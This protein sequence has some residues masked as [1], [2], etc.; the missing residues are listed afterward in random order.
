MRYL[1]VGIKVNGLLEI[2][3][4]GADHAGTDHVKAKARLFQCLRNS[5]KGG[6]D[7]RVMVIT[8][9]QLRDRKVRSKESPVLAFSLQ[10]QQQ[11]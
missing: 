3:V 8:P 4:Q 9:A 6:R 7:R 11:S 10:Q 5:E 2:R 1:R